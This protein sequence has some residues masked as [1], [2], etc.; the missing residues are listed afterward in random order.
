[1]RLAKIIALM[2]MG[3]RKVKSND[4][5]TIIYAYLCI[6]WRAQICMRS[7]QF[8]QTLEEIEE[9]EDV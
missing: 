3:E 7:T 5:K 2:A 9:M 4:N 6:I 1:L 8:T